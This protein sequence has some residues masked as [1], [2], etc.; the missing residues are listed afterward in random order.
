M[1]GEEVI[2]EGEEEEGKNKW[3]RKLLTDEPKAGI[4][5]FWLAAGQERLVPEYLNQE[6]D[7]KL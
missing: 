2:K 3:R 1:P 7:P 4:L 6:D 5:F